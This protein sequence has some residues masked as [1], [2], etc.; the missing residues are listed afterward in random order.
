MKQINKTFYNKINKLEND[1]LNDQTQQYYEIDN[2]TLQII[3]GEDAIKLQIKHWFDTLLNGRYFQLEYGNNLY[4]EIFKRKKDMI[5]FD[6]N[7]FIDKLEKDLQYIIIINRDTSF[8]NFTDINNNLVFTI[9]LNFIVKKSN[10]I[11]SITLNS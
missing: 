6:L 10:I 3:D 4:K 2:N 7:L 5:N 1:I 8:Y 11:S 9:T